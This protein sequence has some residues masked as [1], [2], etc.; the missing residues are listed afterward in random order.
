MQSH[1]ASVNVQGES[2]SAAMQLHFSFMASTTSAG[3]I[4][5][6][7]GGNENQTHHCL[8]KL[9]KKCFLPRR[10]IAVCQENQVMLTD[11]PCTETCKSMGGLLAFAGL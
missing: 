1:R 5:S 8:G 4:S 11:L 6:A 2:L 3:Q 10:S 9:F 7:S